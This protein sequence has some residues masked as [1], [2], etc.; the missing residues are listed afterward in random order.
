MTAEADEREV[1][2]N[3]EMVWDF[4]PRFFSIG[5]VPTPPKGVRQVTVLYMVCGL[6]AV[7]IAKA[8]G[9]FALFFGLL[10]WWLWL[11][12]VGLFAA[13]LALVEV[14]GLR[15]HQ[16]IPVLGRYVVAP[17]HLHGW[18]TCAADG[19]RWEMAELAL[20][21]DGAEPAFSGMLYTGP[22]MIMRTRPAH[23]ATSERT[24]RGRG[25]VDLTLTELPGPALEEPKVTRVPAGR[26]VA[27]RP[28]ERAR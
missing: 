24:R 11:I 3:F 25:H 10:P 8:M 21:P 20:I 26:T 7:L 6:V 14:Q 18:T 15:A 22:G 28:Q 12:G 9:V 17:K 23:R 16:F 4:E 27:I 1:V 19:Q 5:E 13:G 2:Q